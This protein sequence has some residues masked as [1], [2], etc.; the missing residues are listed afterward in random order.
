MDGV[1]SS[2]ANQSTVAAEPT[3]VAPETG[4]E[5][6]PQVEAQVPAAPDGAAPQATAPATAGLPPEA[7][8]PS[9]APAQP[10]VDLNAYQAAQQKAQ[11][12]DQLQQELR[13]LAMQRQREDAQRQEQTQLAQQREQI[14]A[15]AQTMAPEDA[16]QFI[17]RQYDQILAQSEQRRVQR[18]QEMQQQFYATMV[19]ATTPAYARH[20]AQQHGLPAEYEQRLAMLA[21]PDMDRYLPVIKQEYQAQK[22]QQE[23]YQRLANELDQLKRS[24][25]ATGLA[26]NGAHV[27][28]GAGANPA[29]NPNG[30]QPE[31]GTIE[32]L[33]SNPDLAAMFG[34]GS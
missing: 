6:T 8:A 27:V 25:Q 21:P 15:M 30:Q 4:S 7:P 29:Y 12:F 14:R 5:L 18:E 19:Q 9:P 20:L 22:T 16:M 33:L 10:T 17:D 2:I 24:Q 23:N 32:H 28:G 13:Q 3:S 31:K 11:Q 34:V 1:L 26:Q